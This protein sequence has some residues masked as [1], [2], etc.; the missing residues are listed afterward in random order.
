MSLPG[1]FRRRPPCRSRE[2]ADACKAGRRGCSSKGGETARLAGSRSDKVVLMPCNQMNRERDPR[3]GPVRAP[4]QERG[5]G[6]PTGC[7]PTCSCHGPRLRARRGAPS[8]APAALPIQLIRSTRSRLTSGDRD[9]CRRSSRPAAAMQSR[10]RVEAAA[11]ED[12]AESLLVHDDVGHPSS[13]QR[14][15]RRVV[16]K[17][18]G[19]L[20]RVDGR[21]GREP[22][23]AIQDWPPVER[24][25]Q[26]VRRAA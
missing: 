19:D 25:V 26:H 9:G 12:G 13:V 24:G 15:E 10:D 20:V 14:D 22:A 4:R 17:A 16:W 18:Q 6:S 5:A 23:V 2:D 1:E 11:A 3:P 21:S 7:S 8:A